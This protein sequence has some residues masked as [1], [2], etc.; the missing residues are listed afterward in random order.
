MVLLFCLLLD[1]PKKTNHLSLFVR[2]GSGVKKGGKFFCGQKLVTW[3]LLTN[4]F[5]IEL[6]LF[7]QFP[8]NGVAKK[9]KDKRVKKGPGFF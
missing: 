7:L 5:T 1:V 6:S 3:I 4:D 8:I 2:E 9:K